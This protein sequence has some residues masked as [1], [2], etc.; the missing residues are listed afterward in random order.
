M[1]KIFSPKVETS[2]KVEHFEVE[3]TNVVTSPKLETSPKPEVLKLKTPKAY[4]C[5]TVETPAVVETSPENKPCLTIV[6]EISPKNES[7]PEST[8]YQSNKEQETVQFPLFAGYP[9]D[10]AVEESYV[11]DVNTSVHQVEL[12]NE[13]KINETLMNETP[14]EQNLSSSKSEITTQL[15]QQE[16]G[17]INAQINEQEDLINF[18]NAQLNSAENN[19]IVLQMK[20]DAILEEERKRNF[21]M[22]STIVQMP[23]KDEEIEKL[24]AKIEQLRTRSAK[25]KSMSV[26]KEPETL[27]SSTIVIEASELLRLRGEVKRVKVLEEEIAE[28]Q[29]ELEKLQVL[30]NELKQLLT[31]EGEM[32]NK[33]TQKTDILASLNERLDLILKEEDIREA[34]LQSIKE[35]KEALVLEL[36]QVREKALMETIDRENTLDELNMVKKEMEEKDV[37]YRLER[38]NLKKKARADMDEKYEMIDD[39]E[40]KIL[41]LEST[42]HILFRHDESSKKTIQNITTFLTSLNAVFEAEMKEDG[43]S[44]KLDIEVSTV[45]DKEMQRQV[46]KLESGIVKLKMENAMLKSNME[47]ANQSSKRTTRVLDVLRESMEPD[48]SSPQIIKDMKEQLREQQDLVNQLFSKKGCRN[49]ADK[50]NGGISTLICLLEAAIFGNAKL[51]DAKVISDV[52]SPDGQFGFDRSYAILQEQ[53]NRVRDEVEE[54]LKEEVKEELNYLHTELMNV[55]KEN[56]ALRLTLNVVHEKK[57]EARYKGTSK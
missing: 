11:E 16:L 31:S 12:L 1:K 17:Q 28:G 54:E 8:I 27:P 10:E 33:L 44:P 39:L 52:S 43:V 49:I 50:L 22:Q 45:F 18:L 30:N 19:L 42:Q 21:V 7:A 4:N 41:V 2:T 13:S 15:K 47:E 53:K 25:W 20:K 26:E 38:H 5:L 40:K 35:S 29:A 36:Q 34:E 57:M 9:K 55:Q 48:A 6:T 32:N 24:T 46:V 51:F 3:T 23:S 56:E 37:N 14:Q